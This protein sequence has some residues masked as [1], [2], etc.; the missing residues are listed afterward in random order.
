MTT[1]SKE[2]IALTRDCPATAVPYGTQLTLPAGTTVSIVQ[3]LGGSITIQTEFGSLFRIDGTDADAL[4]VDD[5]GRNRKVATSAAFAMSDVTAALQDVYD[6]EIPISVVELGLIYR[7][8]EVLRADGT[9]LIS[10][11]MSMTAPG[12]GMGDVLRAD[13]ERVVRMVPGVDAVEV[14]LVWDPPWNITRMSDA[15][16]LQLGLL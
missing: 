15:V 3:T 10:I 6:P 14:D 5:P 8:E 4:G 16:R 1:A 12:C 13:A 9:R 2:L 7:C 11:D